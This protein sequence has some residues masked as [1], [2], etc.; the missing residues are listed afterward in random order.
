MFEVT[1]IL[2]VLGVVLGSFLN[3]CIYRIPRGLSI[4]SISSFCPSCKRHLKWH[5]II[6]IL[7]FVVFKGKCPRCFVRIPTFY[8]VNEVLV[9]AIVLILFL[10]YGPT[11]D[12]LY[13]ISFITLMILI[14][15]IDRNH[16]LI[17]NKIILVGF[18]MG[19][20]LNIVLYSPDMLNHL[21]SSVLGLCTMICV[22]YGGNWV[23]KKQTMGMGDVKLAGLVGLF[24]GFQN[25]L[26]A[27][28]LA[29]ILGSVYGWSLKIRARNRVKVDSGIKQYNS[30]DLKLPFGSF[31]AIT[32]SIVLVF[33]KQINI[34]LESWLIWLQ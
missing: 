9:G 25:L 16:F 33:Q 26:I 28:W 31:V 19:M 3:V 10:S 5:E 4:V 15:E 34:A 13:A 11:G 18:L 2:I 7:S 32:A 14:A 8:A 17:P 21:L 24:L 27:F 30:P 29:T 6:P 23:F 1:S 22:M 20:I 12:Y